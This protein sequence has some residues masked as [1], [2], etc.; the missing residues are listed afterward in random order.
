MTEQV[1]IQHRFTVEKDGKSF[2]DAIVLPISEYKALSEVQIE[3]IKNERFDSWEKSVLNPP[4]VEE[5]PVEEKISAIEDQID[6]LIAQKEALEQ[7]GS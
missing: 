7:E 3:Q 5:I 4:V 6:Q 1:F 2:S